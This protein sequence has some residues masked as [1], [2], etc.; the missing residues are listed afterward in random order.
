MRETAFRSCW[1]CGGRRPVEHVCVPHNPIARRGNRTR[2]RARAI[3][4]TE[5]GWTMSKFGRDPRREG[6]VLP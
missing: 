1:T 4:L 5:L 2:T 3:V 6:E